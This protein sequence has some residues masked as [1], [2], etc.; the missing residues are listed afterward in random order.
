MLIT[1]G[2]RV[3]P[4][5][6]PA[7]APTPEEFQA[8]SLPPIESSSLNQWW[9]NFNDS[10]LERLVEMAAEQNLDLQQAFYRVVEARAR[11][12]V[13]RGGFFPAFASTADVARRKRSLSSRPFVA[14]NGSPFDFFSLGIDSV[15]E[16]DLFGKQRRFLEGSEAEFRRDVESHHDGQVT[17]YADVASTYIQYRLIQ[18][19]R[20]IVQANLAI[21]QRTVRFAEGRMK[22]GQVS[23]LDLV[24]ARAQ[25]QTTSATLP[26]FDEQAQLALNRLHVLLGQ[27]PGP[28]LANHL[29]EG[30]IPAPA[31]TLAIGVPADLIRRRPDIRRSEQELV[32][33]NAQIGAA[34]ADFYPQLSLLGSISVDSRHLSSLF[35]WNST[36]FQLGPSVRWNVLQFGRIQSNVTAQQARFQRLAVAYRSTV[37]R[38]VQEVEDGLV[39]HQSQSRRADALSLAAKS[40]AEAVKLSTE[41]YNAGQVTIQ[42]ILDAQTRLLLTEQD[43]ALSQATV[44]LN[45]IRVYKAAGGGWRTLDCIE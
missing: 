45:L 8:V 26:Q 30:K 5:F 41:R 3:G 23:R 6:V 36:V 20:K 1:S 9:V 19:L 4:D 15:W 22:A 12:G 42:R 2:C 34:I 35:Q 38:A 32:E 43:L 29:G 44:A 25:M 37:L 7:A 27:S 28:E 11:M 21:Q 10:G 31:S 33:A 18:S 17:L 24:E 13:V 16:V 14:I 39:S 40:S